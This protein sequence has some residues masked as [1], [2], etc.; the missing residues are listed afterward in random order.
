MECGRQLI[1]EINDKDDWNVY[2]FNIPNPNPFITLDWQKDASTTLN[3]SKSYPPTS[4]F[5]IRH[6]EEITHKD[7]EQVKTELKSGG[8]KEVVFKSEVEFDYSTIKTKTISTTK[9][10][11]YDFE[12]QAKLLKEFLKNRDYDVTDCGAL[13]FDKEDDYPDFVS[14]VAKEVSVDFENAKLEDLSSA[15][16]YEKSQLLKKY[17][18]NAILIKEIEEALVGLM[19]WKK[20]NNYT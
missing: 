4:Y 9:S 7:K 1:W 5:R 16:L 13:A 14:C 18:K 8:A 17:P 10:N 2:G 12:T 3:L 19:R 20:E 6:K 15:I 11:L